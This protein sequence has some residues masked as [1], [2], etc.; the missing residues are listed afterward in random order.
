MA[1]LSSVNIEQHVNNLSKCLISSLMAY[2]DCTD[3]D[4]AN[5]SHRITAMESSSGN[6]YK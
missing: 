6:T 2:S 5:V 1:K 4:W 3:G